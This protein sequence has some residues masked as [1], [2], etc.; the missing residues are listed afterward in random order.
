MNFGSLKSTVPLSC[1]LSFAI[2]AIS[3]SASLKSKMLKFSAMRLLWVLFGIATIPR[4]VSQR[5][6]T[7]E[8][9]LP[10]FRPICLSVALPKTAS[11]PCPPSG[12]Q[13]VI[14]VPYSTR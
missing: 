5:N 6:A 3:S 7:C 2:V 12:P 8:A 1:M 13:A 14:L 4:Y 9:V 10:Y 11:E